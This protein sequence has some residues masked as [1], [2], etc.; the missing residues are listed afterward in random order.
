MN[1][2]L[3]KFNLFKFPVNIHFSFLFLCL[4]FST[5]GVGA[6]VNF[7]IICS[8]F[9]AILGHEMG[10]ASVLRRLRIPSEIHL[11]FFGGQTV[12]NPSGVRFHHSWDILLNV[13]GVSVNIIIAA[14]CFLIERSAMPSHPFLAV[15][16]Q[17]SFYVNLVLAVL[18]LCPV[19][20]LDGGKLLHNLLAMFMKPKSAVLTTLS[21]S[22]VTALML[23]VASIVY[24]DYLFA[25]ILFGIFAFE[26]FHKL[27][28]FAAGE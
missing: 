3:L 26:N 13:A 10:H 17:V 1:Q 16:I 24:T 25:P 11:M 21:I 15:F 20:P 5:P 28:A 8:I 4:V 23:A 18:N 12:W 7:A 2:V 22:F 27:T 19:L 9:V 14:I 6:V